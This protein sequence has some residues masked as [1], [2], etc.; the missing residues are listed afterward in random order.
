LAHPGGNATGFANFDFNL[1]GKWLELLKE[2]SPG[3][4]RVAIIRNPA[5]TIGA[6]F[7]IG[8]TGGIGQ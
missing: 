5:S 4:T 3:V 2:I 7:S 1:G 8:S 6:I